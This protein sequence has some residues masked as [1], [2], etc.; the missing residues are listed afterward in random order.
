[1]PVPT[2][3]QLENAAQQVQAQQVQAQL[4]AKGHSVTLGQVEAGLAKLLCVDD[5][6]ELG[7]RTQDLDAIQVWQKLVI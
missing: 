1:M 2:K 4:H 7:V 3:P 6:Q 5:L